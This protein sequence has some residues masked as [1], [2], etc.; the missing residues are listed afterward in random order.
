[1]SLGKILLP[2]GVDLV[3]KNYAFLLFSLSWDLQIGF[4]GRLD[5]QKG[6]DLIRW[7]TPELTEDDVQFISDFSIY[8]IT[9]IHSR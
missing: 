3:V 2:V 6:I 9:M 8:L 1:M 7:A 4:I 5:Y